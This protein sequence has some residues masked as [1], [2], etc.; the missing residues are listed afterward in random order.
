M[1]RDHKILI[2]FSLILLL[3]ILQG[4]T[5]YAMQNNIMEETR[6]IKDVE[7][8][9]EVM[10]ERGL[11][12]RVMLIEEVDGAML[13]ALQGQHE[14]V[15]EHRLVYIWLVEKERGLLQEARVILGRS[16]IPLEEKTLIEDQLIILESL[17]PNMTLLELGGFEAIE[18]EEFE[19][20]YSLLIGR[21][22]KIYKEKLFLAYQRWADIQHELTISRSNNLLVRSQQTIYLNLGLCLISILLIILTLWVIRSFITEKYLKERR[23]K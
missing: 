12:Y 10:A 20:A 4:L 16:E 6:Q 22:H 2:G 9:L 21:D 13:H 19:L 1:N 18:K 17:G 15:E 3:V 5:T 8:P 11:G 23:N 14:D 7:S